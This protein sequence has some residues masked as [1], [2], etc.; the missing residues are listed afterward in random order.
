VVRDGRLLVTPWLKHPPGIRSDARR[1]QPAR[2]PSEEEELVAVTKRVLVAWR[3]LPPLTWVG[4]DWMA[5]CEMEDPE[6]WV[7][8]R[9]FDYRAVQVHVP[10]LTHTS[11]P[12]AMAA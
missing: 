6:T 1:S 9:P 11:R 5:A 12:P 4:P 10:E 7:Q 3:W 2:W 8:R